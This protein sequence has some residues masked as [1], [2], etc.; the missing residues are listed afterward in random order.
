[1]GD[2][3]PPQLRRNQVE[4]GETLPPRRSIWR[5]SSE[6]EFGENSQFPAKCPRL[7]QCPLLGDSLNLSSRCD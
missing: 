4:V 7:A 6:D 5:S 3:A 2:A 1:M